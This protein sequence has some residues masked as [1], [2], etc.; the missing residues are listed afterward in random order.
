MAVA[1]NRFISKSFDKYRLFFQLFHKN[2]TFV[3]NEEC[4]LALQQFKL[5]LTKSPLL[6]T[7]DEGELLYVYLA[8]SKHAV[9][10]MLLKEVDGDQRPIYFISKIFT[11]YQMRYLL[12]E[13]LVLTL[14]ITTRK[15]MHYF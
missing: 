9:S 13:K 10:L 2:T 8:I 15:L 5:Y 14:V 4:E 7:L 6:S 1:L 11:N 12:L 3:W